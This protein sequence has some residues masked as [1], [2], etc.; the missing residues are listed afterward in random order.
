MKK[1]HPLCKDCEHFG[2]RIYGDPTEAREHGTCHRT[3]GRNLVDGDE[4]FL[5]KLAERERNLLSGCGVR[6]KY[7]QPI[8]A[9]GVNGFRAELTPE[10]IFRAYQQRDYHRKE[11]AF[12]FA[13][14]F[15][16][17]DSETNEPCE[18]DVFDWCGPNDFVVVVR[19]T[20]PKD[21]D[22][23]ES[24]PLEIEFNALL[25]FAYCGDSKQWGLVKITQTK[26][27]P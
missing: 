21:I 23:I 20:D 15:I 24:L 7:F 2:G 13:S 26:E 22:N 12:A 1:Q 19:A 3:T 25:E 11:I 17:P 16:H 6:G 9:S 4:I 14:V 18:F 8:S 10:M 5:G 27:T